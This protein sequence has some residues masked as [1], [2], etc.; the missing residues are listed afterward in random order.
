MFRKSRTQ[1]FFILNILIWFGFLLSLRLF[2]LG[3][4]PQQL[5]SWSYL[6][7]ALLAAQGIAF[8]LRKNI[9]AGIGYYISAIL[10]LVIFM[11]TGA[12]GYVLGNI[13]GSGSAWPLLTKGD[14]VIGRTFALSFQPGV[15]VRAEIEGKS[16]IKRIHGVPGDQI[17]ICDGLVY[18][19]DI[20]YQQVN[21]WVGFR[22]E[23]AAQCQREYR[24]LQLAA[25]EYFVLGDNTNQSRD[26][27]QYG[28]VPRTALYENFLYAIRDDMTVRYL[29]AEFVAPAED[30][31]AGQ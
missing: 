8:A 23:N 16:S 28:P 11:A 27:R 14:L 15:M 24:K 19:N 5:Q 20:A 29:T 6:G 9:L 30:K 26:S 31:G 7:I 2:Q 12:I 3:D 17:T 10:L 13:L 1:H 21:N 22:F 25:D 4:S 18:V